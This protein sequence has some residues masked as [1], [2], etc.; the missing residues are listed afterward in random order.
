[1]LLAIKLSQNPVEISFSY[2]WQVC[3]HS[4]MGRLVVSL[5][6]GFT[7]KQNMCRTSS[8]QAGGDCVSC[9]RRF[10]TKNPKPRLMSA[11]SMITT[12]S[13]GSCEGLSYSLPLPNTPRQLLDCGSRVQLCGEICIKKQKLTASDNTVFLYVY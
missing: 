5:H 7:T 6:G 8:R 1:M 9:A 3:G 13:G 4:S 11:D 12:S 10:S 2:A